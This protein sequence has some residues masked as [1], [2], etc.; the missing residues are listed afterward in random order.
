MLCVMERYW[1]N[2]VRQHNEAMRDEIM[3][4]RLANALRANRVSL[5]RRLVGRIVVRIGRAIE[6]KNRIDFGP[7]GELRFDHE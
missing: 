4:H 7:R 1:L 5:W 3:R 2:V 6:G